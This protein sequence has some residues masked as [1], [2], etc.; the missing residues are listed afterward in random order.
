VWCVTPLPVG[1]PFSAAMTPLLSLLPQSS[2][3][4]LLVYAVHFVEAG[5]RALTVGLSARCQELMVAMMMRVMQR[6][7]F[8]VPAHPAPTE[9]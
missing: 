2:S 7:S 8:P 3:V 1:S 4:G 6:H 9:S 5:R